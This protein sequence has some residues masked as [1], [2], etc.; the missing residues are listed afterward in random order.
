MEYEDAVSVGVEQDRL[1]PQVRLIDGIAN[2][3]E[4]SLLELLD[5]LVDVIDLEVDA[6]ARNRRGAVG[7]VER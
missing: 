2:E 3:V 4:P 6:G 1:A 7:L 5:G